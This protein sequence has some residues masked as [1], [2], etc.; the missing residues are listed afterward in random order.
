MGWL[1]TNGGNKIDLYDPDPEQISIDDIADGLSKVCR[2]NGQIKRFYSVA[3][4]CI[5]VAN[6]VPEADKLAALLH[7]ASE[8][9]ICDV[10]TPL[11]RMLGD[12]Y[13]DVEN[14][15]QYAIG[16][17]FGVELVN[18][19]D[20]VKAAD[21][22]MLVTEHESLQHKALDWG[23]DYDGILRYPNF[24]PSGATPT[25]M[26]DRY[27]RMLGALLERRHLQENPL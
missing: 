12:V 17:K 15:V 24:Q 9:Y 2:F 23:P 22:V 10:P 19:P 6:L 7:D 20:V 1:G 16:R 8:A 13:K 11:K 26:A 4:H 18:L 21:R 3:E 27:K 14:R 5:N 25:I